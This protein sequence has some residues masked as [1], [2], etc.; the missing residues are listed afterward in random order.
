LISL[1]RIEARQ[2]IWDTFDS[3]TTTGLGVA[4]TDYVV[5]DHQK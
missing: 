3:M 4:H 1:I 5:V 2:E